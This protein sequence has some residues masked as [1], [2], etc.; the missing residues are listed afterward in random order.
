MEGE[1]RGAF[2]WVGVRCGLW[3]LSPA[4]GPCR[5]LRRTSGTLGPLLSWT[6][7]VAGPGIVTTPPHTHTLHGVT[8]HSHAGEP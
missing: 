7:V 1:S 3:G 2:G 6:G 8:V 4:L 5:T